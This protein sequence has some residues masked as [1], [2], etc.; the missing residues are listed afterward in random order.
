[1]DA[2]VVNAGSQSLKLRVIDERDQVV[3]STDLERPDERLAD[4][5]AGFVGQLR[6]PVAVSGHRVVHGGPDFTQAVV[7][8]AAVR[9]RLETVNDLAPLHNPFALAGIDAVRALL[10]EV[11]TLACFDTAFHSSLE[12]A[13]FAYA[14]PDD[15]VTRWGVRRYGFHGLSC[16]WATRRAA[17]LVGRPPGD[18]R[19]VVC[20][21]GAGASVT[22][23]AAGRSVDTT[24]GF[25]P[26]EGLVMA[27]RC[28][29]IDPGLVLWVL[30][31]GLGVDDAHDALEHRS[32]LFGLSRGRSPDM[33]QLLAARDAHDEAAGLALSVYLHRLVAKIAAMA[34]AL[35]GS[36]RSGL[37]GWGRRELGDH[38]G[39]NGGGAGLD[40]SGDR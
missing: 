31:H 4:Q 19:M 34:A 17:G 3:A 29:D 18:L 10:P 12:P 38:P 2:L 5:I 1:M 15:W 11:P 26:L 30:Q 37:H 14:V 36:G 39:R 40:R 20:H 28:G 35:E 21:L 25:T 32:G 24:M 6:H 27:T 9:A 7:V 16:A 8:D 23:V 22:A 13:A 33:R